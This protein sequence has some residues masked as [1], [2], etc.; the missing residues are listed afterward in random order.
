M[1]RILLETI[2]VAAKKICM[3]AVYFLMLFL[4]PLIEN[5]K[6]GGA[7]YSAFICL[8]LFYWIGR[9]ISREGRK[10]ISKER[11]PLVGLFIGAM[12]EI[13]TALLCAVM[14]LW[15]AS[16]KWANIAYQVY[17]LAFIGFLKPDGKIFTL[18]GVSPAFLIPVVL[19]P[20]VCAAAYYLGY[21][22]IVFDGT[23]THKLI[24]KKTDGEDK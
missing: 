15:P 9:D 12:A 11:S 16:F 8:L 1:K 17:N 6:L 4:L 20:L 2:K 24:Y 3:T 22:K 18:A 21:K 14:F 10:L 5:V 23:I 19:T 13:P 7:L